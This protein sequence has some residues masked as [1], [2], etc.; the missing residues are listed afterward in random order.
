MW[1]T[2]FK[3]I[4]ISLAYCRICLLQCRC[5][6]LLEKLFKIKSGEVDFVDEIYRDFSIKNHSVPGNKFEYICAAQGVWRG[7]ELHKFAKCA[8]NGYSSDT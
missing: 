2:Q 5:F 1:G 6:C 3:G 4:P 7:R 8:K